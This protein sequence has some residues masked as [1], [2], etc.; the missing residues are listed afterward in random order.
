[1]S[2]KGFTIIEVIIVITVIGLTLPV[3]FSFYFTLLQQ[4]AKIYRLNTVKKDGDYLINQIENTIKDRA[5]M[6]LS[7]NLPIPPD[8]TNKVCFDDSSSY[9]T[10]SNLYFLDEDSN[11][12]GYIADSR[13]ISS[14]SGNLVTPVELA[15]SKTIINN[16]SISCSR[17]Y[18]FSPPLILLS[19]DICYD[20]GAGVCTSNKPEEVA[21]LHYQTRIKM[22]NQ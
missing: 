20:T 2:K 6:I 14:D 15:S 22:R 13:T 17:T 16:F 19:F 12:F 21:T 1:M 18:S 10:T 7:S 8:S 3:I 5:T 11:W 9:S 4:Q